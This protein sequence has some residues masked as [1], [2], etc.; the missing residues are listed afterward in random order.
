MG[1]KLKFR[2]WNGT[3]YS[4][5]PRLDMMLLNCSPNECYIAGLGKVIEQYTGLEDKNG[6][7]IYEGDMLRCSGGKLK[8]K[9]ANITKEEM[10]AEGRVISHKGCFWCVDFPLFDYEELEIINVE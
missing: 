9:Y 10:V 8:L 2:V 4:V 6:H 1:Q 5:E 7:E 3:K